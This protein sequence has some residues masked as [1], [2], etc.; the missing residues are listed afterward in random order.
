MGL[1]E[2]EP[3]LSLDFGSL[4]QILLLSQQNEYL[5]SIRTVEG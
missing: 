1:R 3:L 5:S 2:I 4:K